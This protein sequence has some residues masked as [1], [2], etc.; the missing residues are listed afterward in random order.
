MWGVGAALQQR[1]IKKDP[2]IDCLA[3]LEA[4][5]G[6]PYSTSTANEVNTADDGLITD[7]N[8]SLRQT[9][10]SKSILRAENQKVD[11]QALPYKSE[12]SAL[13]C[14]ADAQ[15]LPVTSRP[16]RKRSAEFAVSEK[17]SN[18]NAETG[19][20][21]V[22]VEPSPSPTKRSRLTKELTAANSTLAVTRPT[23][24]S[25]SKSGRTLE[26]ILTEVRK[27]TDNTKLLKLYPTISEFIDYLTQFERSKN[28]DVTKLALFGCRIIYVNPPF[29]NRRASSAT[30]S[31][32]NKM[33]ISLRTQICHA[34]QNGAELIKPEDFVGSEPDWN[35]FD[36]DAK[37]RA[38]AG[39]WTS[40]VIPLQLPGAP[41]PNFEAILKCLG[42]NGISV[43]DLGPLVE[44]VSHDWVIDSV[45]ACSPTKGWEP[46][47]GDPRPPSTRSYHNSPTKP[48][49]T[50][51]RPAIVHEDSGDLPQVDY[52][53]KRDQIS[54]VSPNYAQTSE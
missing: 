52:S 27:I 38:D 34:V 31:I 44:I 19:G 13:Q 53:K 25:S 39:N 41:K 11:E 5:I 50:D 24:K 21:V 6:S 30:T 47:S 23:R 14:Q 36:S 46:W 33:D 16:F 2:F 26:Q 32:R 4:T 9:D 15:H 45:K 3:T 42:P 17:P 37:I 7:S 49:Q 48:T 29:Q 28:V 18:E 1:G 40:H 20:D 54:C 8:L 51:T 43:E 35:R 12:D 22:I 10:K